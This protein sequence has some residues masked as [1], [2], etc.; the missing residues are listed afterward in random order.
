M[1]EEKEDVYY[2]IAIV[3][4][5]LVIVYPNLVAYIL[6]LFLIFYGALM[7]IK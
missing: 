7:I 2:V 6:G 5:I 1:F 3:V 4:G